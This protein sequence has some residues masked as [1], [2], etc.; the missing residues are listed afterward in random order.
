MRKT[1]RLLKTM[2]MSKPGR[3]VRLALLVL[4]LIFG[5]A[6]AWLSLPA[7]A[8]QRGPVQ[9]IVEGEVQG[10]DGA[11]ISGAIVYLKDS[12]SLAMKS[13]I[14][15]DKGHFRFVQLSPN[16][17]YDLWAELKGKHSKTKS[18]SSFDSKNDFVF[19]LTIA[20]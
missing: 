11:A 4:A 8:Q 15:D 10:K 20:E 19:T 6:P 16:S 1:L 9:R 13:F 12:K 5:T 3:P 18:V 7:A 2:R 17:D 14:S